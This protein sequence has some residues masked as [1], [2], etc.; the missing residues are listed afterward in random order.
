L[1]RV[2]HEFWRS[3]GFHLLQRDA[4]GWLRVT[5]HF[6]RAYLARPE[7]R[8]VEESCP[9]EHALYDAL[10][11]NPV[12]P[13]AEPEIEAIKDADARENYRIVLRF[14]DLLTEHG[15]IEASYLAI[16]TSGRGDIP[17]L[18]VEQ[19]VH[20]I[21]RNVLSDCTDPMRLRAAELFFREQNVSL[22]EGRVM[23]A[24]EEVVDMFAQSG[25]M[26]G[27]GQLLVES[28]T[29]MRQ[30]DLDV[31]DD[32]NKD[33]YW[34]RSDRFDTVIDFRFTQPALDAFARVMEAWIAHFLE[35]RVRIQPVQE[36]RDERWS[37]H[38]GLDAEAT[39][40]LNALYEDEEV[41]LEEL[42]QIVGLFRLDFRDDR[43]VS[44]SMRGKPVYLGIAMTPDRKLRMKPQNLLT[45]LP[46]SEG[47]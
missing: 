3:S 39:R 22:D 33:I 27:L 9:A 30:I 28:M 45:N 20:A 47:A 41:S 5:P 34:D 37:W 26:G 8:P 42:E 36:I 25:G 21:V 17:S 11:E 15:T 23:L 43:G 18:F 7:M 40:I 32:D 6:L 46:L 2:S 24:D 44:A 14:R 10:L 31:L 35:M 16:V 29:P 4:R 19:L 38:I 1:T 13:V 12:R